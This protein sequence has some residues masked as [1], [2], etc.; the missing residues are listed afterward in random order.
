MVCIK[1]L[2]EIVSSDWVQADICQSQSV[3]REQCLDNVMTCHAGLLDVRHKSIL[4]FFGSGNFTEGT[5]IFT[6]GFLTILWRW[7][8]RHSKEQVERLCL[9]ALNWRYLTS[10][11]FLLLSWEETCISRCKTLPRVFSYL[12]DEELKT[13]LGWR[14]SHTLWDITSITIKAVSRS[15]SQILVCPHPFLRCIVQ[16]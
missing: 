8:L 10:M 14:E 1:S 9:W 11:H 16:M 7:P 4:Y 6:N 3:C 5:R 12:G 2:A 15:L 13:L